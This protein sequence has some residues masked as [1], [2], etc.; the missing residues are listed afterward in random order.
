MVLIVGCGGSPGGDPPGGSPG[1]VPRGGSPVGSLGGPPG[2]SP[3]G[4][5][6]RPRGTPWGGFSLACPPRV[7]V[8]VLG[9]VVWATGH[10]GGSDAETNEKPPSVKLKSLKNWF[11]NSE[12]TLEVGFESGTLI[13][14]WILSLGAEVHPGAPW[15][16]IPWGVAKESGV[17]SGW[18]DNTRK[19]LEITL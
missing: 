6:G 4:S 3:G 12:L 15:W 13:T 16:T 5:L 8:P 11:R 19:F 1:A 18:S 7:F 2:G 9:T 17:F 10:L 14:P